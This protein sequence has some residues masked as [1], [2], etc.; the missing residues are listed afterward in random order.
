ML[1]LALLRF[2]QMTKPKQRRPGPP[3]ANPAGG[4][5]ARSPQP[6]RPACR[7][8]DRHLLDP[9][10]DHPRFPT[11]CLWCR[12]PITQ[13]ATG[14]PRR[15][16]RH[17]CRQQAYQQRRRQRAAH[18]AARQADQLR[19]Q[20]DG[21]TLGLHDLADTLAAYA[22]GAPGATA[23]DPARLAAAVVELAT[24]GWVTR[25]YG[26]HH[27]AHRLHADRQLIRRRRATSG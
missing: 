15:Y 1:S 17:S 8:F 7:R 26:S 20:L 3:A 4:P 9:P 24:P 16:C 5:P 23:P 11:A 13:A 19:W 12:R 21:L 18:A 25:T 14:R 6:P 10:G 2:C 27:H 22:A